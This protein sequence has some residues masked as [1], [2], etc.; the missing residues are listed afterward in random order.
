MVW[1]FNIRKKPK[2][3]GGHYYIVF[4]VNR[5]LGAGGTI[6]RAGSIADARNMIAKF[7]KRV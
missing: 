5:E 7:R 1:K 6:G 4:A 2:K 3:N